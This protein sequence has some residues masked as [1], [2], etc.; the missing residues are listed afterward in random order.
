MLDPSVSAGVSCGKPSS[1]D[2]LDWV[3]VYNLV[4]LSFH[5]NLRARNPTR[6]PLICT[7]S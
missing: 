7:L 2:C 3:C 1:Q 4:T 6:L 5:I